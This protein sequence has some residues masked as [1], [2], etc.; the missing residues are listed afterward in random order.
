MTILITGGGGFLGAAVARQLLARGEAV[1]VLG[2][3]RYPAV[4][5]A[6]AEGIQW[7]LSQ[8]S[9]GLAE[10][11]EGF[12]AV[13]HTAA[14][15]GVWGERAVYWSIN[16][17]GTRRLIEACRAAG[18]PKLVYTGSPSCTFDG[19]DHEGVTEADVGYPESFE[20]VYPE[21]KAAAEALVLAANGEGLATTSLRPHLIYG[22][23]DPHLLPRV[24]DRNRKGRLRIVG[25]G[26]NKVGITYVDNA[27]AAHVQALDA[28]A[29][30]SA[31]AGKAY[32]ITDPE[33][34]VIWD[35]INQVLAALGE[36]AITRKVP[37]GLA[38]FV[39][40][41]L[42]GAWELF[43]LDGEPP[44]TRFVAAQLSSAHWYDLA[45]A[46]ADFGYAPPVA[47]DVALERTVADLRERFPRS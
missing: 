35:W 38:R 5:E 47:A 16:V 13:I 43:G 11:L 20:A 1:T 34:V 44:M 14:L 41:A 28:L 25:E 15:A 31:N 40:G 3:S 17:D 27:A 18:V 9:P 7:D 10:A 33:P 45:G 21:S 2:R 6:G 24:I 23:G 22:P 42:E 30:G 32:F 29:P 19:A 4:E 8:D 46:R 12:D 26:R 37:T 39:G 36:P